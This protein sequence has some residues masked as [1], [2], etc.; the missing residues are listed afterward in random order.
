MTNDIFAPFWY[1]CFTIWKFI[2]ENFDGKIRAE[3]VIESRTVT[4]KKIS[5]KYSRLYIIEIIEVNEN[6]RFV[7]LLNFIE[8]IFQQFIINLNLI[9]KSLMFWQN[10]TILVYT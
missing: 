4:I 5:L 3:E 2:N 1:I 10:A 7:P 9:L 6:V 8:N